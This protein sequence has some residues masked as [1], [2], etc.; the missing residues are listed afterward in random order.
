MDRVAGDDRYETAAQAA[1]GRFTVPSGSWNRWATSDVVY[2]AT[3]AGFADALA[4]GAAAAAF[5]APLLLTRPDQ[6]PDSTA[7]ALD[8]LQ[9]SMVVVLG[10]E[11]AVSGAVAS[12]IAD[13][14]SRPAVV[15]AAGDTRYETAVVAS[16]P[17]PS[18]CVAD[19][20]YAL[21]AT[22][23][24]FADA[25]GGAAAAA[26]LRAP[27]MLTP[28][29][30]PTPTSVTTGLLRLAPEQLLVLGGTGA[31][32]DAVVSTLAQTVVR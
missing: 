22:G 17:T 9:P 3:G 18:L 11:A 14:A 13:R 26:A 27:L 15:R 2:V 12:A 20:R 23:T 5:G 28:P 16:C 7:T 30:S 25:L 4:G 24:A 29:A 6:L 31:V 19:T 1:I 10:G 32:T 21:A 8:L